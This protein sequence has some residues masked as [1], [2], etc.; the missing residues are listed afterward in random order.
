MDVCA[1]F[2]ILMHY[3]FGIPQLFLSFG[4]PPKKSDYFALRAGNYLYRSIIYTFHF[5]LPRI[6]N[7]D[8]GTEVVLPTHAAVALF[9]VFP[10]FSGFEEADNSGI[11]QEFWS[12]LLKKFTLHLH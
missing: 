1:L 11:L 3:I 9:F 5:G 2:F 12:E 7:L 4:I 10:N 8:K 6:Q